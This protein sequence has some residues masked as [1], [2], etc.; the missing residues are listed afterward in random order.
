MSE[1]VVWGSQSAEDYRL[2]WL[3]IVE[4]LRPSPADEE[5]DRG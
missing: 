3:R 5:E 2:A 1:F 4:L